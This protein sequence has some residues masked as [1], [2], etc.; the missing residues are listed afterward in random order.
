MSHTY[1]FY[2]TV[3]LTWLKDLELGSPFPFSLPP[4]PID[5]RF[6]RPFIGDRTF[7]DAQVDFLN[8]CLSLIV[9]LIFSWTFIKRKQPIKWCQITGKTNVPTAI[10]FLT[11]DYWEISGGYRYRLKWL[12]SA[13]PFWVT[14]YPMERRNYKSRGDYAHVVTGAEWY[15]PRFDVY[16]LRTESLP[17]ACD[18]LRNIRL[19]P[20]H[21]GI[22]P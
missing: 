21:K 15:P 12:S 18:G 20:T 6:L 1:Q 2:L 3:N 7:N 8:F 5:W 22:A 11:E 17:R 19:V 10:C 4:P 9:R 16:S 14:I 13:V